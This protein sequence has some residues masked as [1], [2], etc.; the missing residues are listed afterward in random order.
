M[1]PLG[2]RK[3]KWPQSCK[4]S[5]LLIH[6]A[7]MNAISWVDGKPARLLHLLAKN[8][9]LAGNLVITALT[10]KFSLFFLSKLSEGEDLL[11]ETI[12]FRLASAN[13][14]SREGNARRALDHLIPL[15]RL[16]K[17]LAN[18]D[19]GNYRQ[20]AWSN[21]FSR[22]WIAASSRSGNKIAELENGIVKCLT[23]SG[24]IWFLAH[25]L[26]PTFSQMHWYLRKPSIA[27]T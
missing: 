14:F 23:A 2:S 3:P 9:H 24:R 8:L 11:Q 26:L 20:L 5:L 25:W 7:K 19:D 12:D 17:K 22:A 21:A 18:N 27:L 13:E 6:P 4:N 16:V 1:T 10:W 15:N